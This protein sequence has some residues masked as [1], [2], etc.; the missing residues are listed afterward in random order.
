M[1]HSIPIRAALAVS[2]IVAAGGPGALAQ[3]VP[4]RASQALNFEL[5]VRTQDVRTEGSTSNGGLGAHAVG[6]IPLGSFLAA[7]L[8]ASYSDATVRTRR[9]LLDVDGS[10]LAARSSCSYNTLDG[11]ATLFARLP[12]WARVGVSYGSGRLSSSCG[13]AS[14]FLQSGDGNLHTDRYQIHGELYF[15]DFT[16]SAT[17]TSTDL[18][19]GPKLESTDFSTSWYPLDSLRIAVSSSD[20][21]DE[22]T[23]GILL[24]HQPEFLDDGLGVYVSYATTDRSPE[25]RTIGLG[26]AYYFGTR[27]ALKTRDREYR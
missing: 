14:M 20:L 8:S 3:D 24:E 9:V 13:E 25:V 27:V 2:L 12:K 23:Y 6:T 15:S 26:F 17:R 1:T 11:A 22:D 21:Y 7:S 5:G 19:G 4:S 18:D 10:K 16:V